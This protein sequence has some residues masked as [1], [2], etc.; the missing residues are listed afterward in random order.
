M[1]T[2]LLL[3][4]LLSFSFLLYWPVT[5]FSQ[6]AESL[7]KAV[8]RSEKASAIIESA[9]DSSQPHIP[10]EI[11][12][13]AKA[14]GV[15]PDVSRVN[16]VME[17]LMIGYGVVCRRTSKGWSLPAYYA[18]KGGKLGLN[19]AGKE[20]P[21]IILLFMD[22]KLVEK[23][24]KGEI[25]L[26][27]KRNAVGG[28]IATESGTGAI[29]VPNKS[30]IVYTLDKG[31]LTNNSYKSSSFLGGYR[32]YPDNNMNKEVYK[33]K[34]KDV[35]GM[36]QFRAGESLPMGLDRLQQKLRSVVQ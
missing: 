15:F 33:L 7:S 19:P 3:L 23:I 8:S 36:E 16:L 29:E 11:I 35:L 14:I 32:I 31:R 24:S 21:D 17:H 34:A 2:K 5:A 20:S 27:G 1:L 28:P 12:Q 30:I 25:Y 13:R 18:F 6:K 22:E 4:I 26:E 10:A 9:L